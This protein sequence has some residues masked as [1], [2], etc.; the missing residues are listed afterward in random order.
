M[1]VVEVHPFLFANPCELLLMLLILVP[2]EV[3]SNGVCEVVDLSNAAQGIL[4]S[5]HR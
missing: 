5:R 3:L 4:G 2:R 1:N